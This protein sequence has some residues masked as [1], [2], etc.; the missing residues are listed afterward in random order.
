MEFDAVDPADIKVEVEREGDESSEQRDHDISELG[1][2][3]LYSYFAKDKEGN[4]VKKT[5]K[6]KK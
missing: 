5:V 4:S 2:G 3:D 6:M 1:L